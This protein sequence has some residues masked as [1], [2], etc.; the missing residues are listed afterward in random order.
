MS[1]GL[2]A[3]LAAKTSPRQPLV[4]SLNQHRNDEA[5]GNT[6]GLSPSPCD[7]P[8]ASEGLVLKMKL[9]LGCWA[10]NT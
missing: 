4:P 3:S 2:R 10:R 9:R 1:D 6:S 8:E 7:R 5:P